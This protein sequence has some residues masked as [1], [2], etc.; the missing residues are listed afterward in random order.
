[1][2]GGYLSATYRSGHDFTTVAKSTVISSLLSLVPLP[3]FPA[4]PYI[5]LTLRSSLGNLGSLVYLH[6]RRPLHLPWRFDWREWC[7]LTKK[8]LWLFAASYGASTGWSVVE[9]TVILKGLGTPALGLW[10]MSTA[11]LESV[12]KVAQAITAVYVPRVIECY[13]RTNDVGQCLRLCRKPVVWG[14]IGMVFMAAAC[15]MA[16]PFIVPVLMPKYAGAI[17]TMCLMMLYLPVLVLELPYILLVA[18]GRWAEQNAFTYAGVVV[19]AV[20]ALLALHLGWGLNGVVGA[21]ITGRLTR[22]GLVFLSLHKARRKMQ[23]SRGV[24]A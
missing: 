16:L 11:L 21:S 23:Q 9:A 10:S 4:W 5:A 22:M 2:Y 17:P 19:F 7:G 15:C 13:G 24:V 8:G 6:L 1:M 18:M 20:L 12:N 14:L 3:L